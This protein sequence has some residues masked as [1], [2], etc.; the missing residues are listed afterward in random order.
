MQKH[1]E[2]ILK[3]L[4]ACPNRN[5]SE[6]TLYGQYGMH[7]AMSTFEDALRYLIDAGMVEKIPPLRV[8]LK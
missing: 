8:R 4:A 5:M 1:H 2:F 3:F 6:T 7:F